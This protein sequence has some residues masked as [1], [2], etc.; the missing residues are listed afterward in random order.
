MAS[1]TNLLMIFISLET[2]SLTSYILAG[3]L[4]HN[5]RSS[6]AAFKYITYGAVAS[7]TMLFGLSFLF[8]MTGTGDLGQISTALTELLAAAKSIPS[9]C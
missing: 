9:P 3:F 6:E 4:T 1:S 7:G 2:V 5:P 8:G